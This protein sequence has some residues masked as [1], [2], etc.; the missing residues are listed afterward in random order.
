[1]EIGSPGG[2]DVEAVTPSHGLLDSAPSPLPLDGMEIHSPGEYLHG[3][4]DLASNHIPSETIEIHTKAVRT[5]EYLH[6]PWFE[7]DISA[8]S[9]CLSPSISNK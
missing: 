4:S 9:Q 8:E 6:I 5:I 2:Y 7:F 1:V 3:P